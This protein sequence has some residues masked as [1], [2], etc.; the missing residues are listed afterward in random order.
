MATIS[1]TTPEQ[2]QG[3]VATIFNQVQ[4]TLGGVPMPLQLLAA[5][6]FVLEHKVGAIGYFMQHPTLEQP[7]QALLRYLAAE[8]EHC[9]FCVDFNEGMLLQMGWTREQVQSAKTDLADTPLST[10]QRTILEL[11]LKA[12]IDKQSL[13]EADVATAKA[14]GFSEQDL[15]EGVFAGMMAVTIDRL[16]EAFDAKAD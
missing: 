2:A 14:Q 3:P 15:L 4:Q 12:A 8:R 11:I 7:T 16:I 6:P 5:S 9:A 10:A 1:I 13:S